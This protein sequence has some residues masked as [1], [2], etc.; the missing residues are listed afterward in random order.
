[1]IGKL[2]YRTEKGEIYN[3][4]S[5]KVL[6]NKRFTNKYKGKIQLIFTSPPF[7]LTKEKKYGNLLG[8]EYIN[9]IANFAP[10]YS[11]L[12][13][14]DGSIV[15][16]IGN[17]WNA[18]SPTMS[19]APIE[20]LLKFKEKGNLNLC[21]EFICNNPSRLPS[22]AFWVN[23]K[24]IR[25]KDSYTRIWWLSKT[26]YPKANNKN[27]LLEYSASMK[28][29]LKTKKYNGGVRPSGHN[30][31]ETSFLKKYKGSIASNFMD[32]DLFSR[33]LSEGGEN[34]LSIANTDNQ[35]QYQ[36]Y[37]KEKNLVIHPARMPIDLARYFIQ[38]LT[39]EE[40]IVLDPFAG[41]N[42]TGLAAEKQNRK[43][44]GIE[45]NEEYIAGSKGRF[46]S[47]TLK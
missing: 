26:E 24:R 2:V 35:K 28:K 32:Y 18:N 4:D 11:N 46:Q 15:I 16:E 37:C 36:K 10:L 13:T 31:G 17:A 9:W 23:H 43:W 44:V 5:Y 8:Q 34:G 33:L 41:S 20:A 30:I 40:D 14:D 22:P 47:D 42:I 29:L 12:L 38:F 6:S 45:M 19:T 3:G 1:M 21:Q 27:I 25:V 7:P 39:D